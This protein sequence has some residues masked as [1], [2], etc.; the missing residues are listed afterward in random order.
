MSTGFGPRIEPSFFQQDAI[1]KLQQTIEGRSAILLLLELRARCFE[2]LSDGFVPAY[3]VRSATGHPDPDSA[4]EML[5]VVGLV[6]ASENGKGE[7]GCQLDWSSQVEASYVRKRRGDGSDWNR[8]Q[9]GNHRSCAAHPGYNCHKNGDYEKWQAE[10]PENLGDLDGDRD[11]HPLQGPDLTRPDLTRLEE[12][13][14]R[15]RDGESPTDGS[16]SPPPLVAGASRAPTSAPSSESE[17]SAPPSPPTESASTE[18]NW[19]E[20]Y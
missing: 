2:T 3:G 1:L 17:E 8:H 9:H 7:P 18:W 12:E 14:G 10:H 20:V 13:E 16:A 11:G 6:V 4:L 19:G 15:E 5:T